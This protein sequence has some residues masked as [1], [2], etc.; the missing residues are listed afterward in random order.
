M[1]SLSLTHRSAAHLRT[2]PVT[3]SRLLVRSLPYDRTSLASVPQISVQLQSSSLLSPSP[4]PLSLLPPPR[5]GGFDRI[6]AACSA[7]DLSV[8]HR[9]RQQRKR[10]HEC[11]GTTAVDHGCGAML[12]LRGCCCVVALCPSDRWAADGG[13][14]SLRPVHDRDRRHLALVWLLDARRP[15]YHPVDAGTHIALS[16]AVLRSRRS[17]VGQNRTQTRDGRDW[18]SF[19]LGC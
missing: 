7:P 4:P 2:L 9:R 19:A 10:R 15:L 6:S 14:A 17:A 1:P 18:S 13:S 3:Q 12:T 11:G 8:A 16:S 5:C